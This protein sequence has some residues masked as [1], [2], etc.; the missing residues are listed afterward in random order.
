M[1]TE[2]TVMIEI[3][4]PALLIGLLLA[5]IAGP[6]GCFVVWGRMAYFGDTLA[7]SAL[8][9]IGLGFLFQLNPTVGVILVT[10]VL[11]LAL[12]VLQGQRFIA[13]DTLLGIMAHGTL[14]LG[15]VLVS[16]MDHVRVDLLGLLFGDLLATS[17]G[18]VA[19]VAL[20]AALIGV[21]LRWVWIPML[22]IAVNQELAQAEGV[23][24]GWIRL[25]FMLLLASTVA[26]GMKV[27]GALLITAMLIIPAAAARKL[28]HTPEQM[29]L[30][31]SAIGMGSVLCGLLLSW[32]ADTPAGPSIV[33]CS[34]SAFVTTF[35]LG[36]RAQ[37]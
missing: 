12:T 35:M 23:K 33:L 1:I 15:L 6:L 13:S 2:A 4:L 7:H 26:I 28:A 31:A 25:L 8:L 22:N 16:L 21:A 19:W 14:A 20:L 29:A 24:V 17:F 34:A 37:A 18:D 11:A 32:L 5:A 9:G 3:L 27:V 30:L 10:S 36:T